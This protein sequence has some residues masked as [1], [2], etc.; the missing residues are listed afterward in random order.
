MLH[1]NIFV[2]LLLSLILLCS[3]AVFPGVKTAAAQE[4]TALTETGLEGQLT[5]EALQALNDDQAEV[6]THNDRVTLVSGTCS[7]E[8]VKSPEDAE[9]VVDSMIGLLGGDAKTHFEPW[10]TFTDGEGNR[11]YVFQQMYANTTVLGGAVKVITDPEGNMIGLSS[12][13]ETELPEAEESEGITAEEAEQIV[14]QYAVEN[15]QPELTLLPDTTAKMILPITIHIDVEEE[16]TEG[17]RFVWVVYTDNPSIRLN[18]AADLPY[19]AHYVT[20]D[21]EYLYSLATIRPGDAAGEAGFDAAYVFEFMEPV[22]YTGYVDLSDGSE[23]ELT[24]T[25]MRDKRTGMYYLGNIERKIVVGDCFEF[26]FN[27]GRVVLASSPDNLE[28]DQVGLLSLYN[29]CKAYDYYKEIGWIGGDG[30]GTPILILNDMCDEHR[31]RIDNAAFIGNYLGWSLFGASMAN[32]LSQ[33]LDVIAHEFTH[34]VTDTVMTY[35]SYMNDYGAINEAISDI[36]GQICDM[37]YGNEA[38][39]DWVI[40]DKSITPVRSMSDPNLFGQPEFSWDLYYFPA[41]NTPT[42]VNDAG[43]VHFNSSLLNN[44]AYRLIADGGMSLE[45]ARAFWFAVDCAMVPGTDYAQLRELMPFVLKILG[46]EKYQT[47]LEQAMDAVR[48]GDHSIPG[49]FDDDRALVTLTLP[50]NENFTDDNWSM[51]IVSVDVNGLILKGTRLISQLISGDYSTFPQEVQDLFKEKDEEPVREE[52]EEEMPGFWEAVLAASLEAIT[53]MMTEETDPEAEA[54]KALAQ[55]QEDERIDEEINILTAWL[56]DEFKDVFYYGV[57]SAGQDGTTI[58]MVARPGRTIPVLMHM[59]LTGISE[60]PDQV[61]FAMY[62]TGKWYA[63]DIP[64]LSSD[65][66]EE[67]IQVEDKEPDEKEADAEM[68]AYVQDIL[69]NVIANLGEIKSLDDVLD[70]FTY[71]IVGGE[72]NEISSNGLET[73]VLP[74]PSEKSEDTTE[75]ELPEPGRKSRPKL[76]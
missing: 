76:D 58:R 46:M 28:W 70:L 24:V 59:S 27:G 12:S 29:Y 4:K 65:P 33:A 6:F 75:M 74:E 64:S 20:M 14:L 2:S 25:V 35:N 23:M 67:N 40:G 68:P 30:Q 22:D 43:G 48:L 57:G 44:V 37:M 18:A 66:D 41:V 61:V 47:T 38:D 54:E 11:Y 16:D 55:A 73:V 21:G 15:N 39:T 56:K 7:E 17:A 9:K 3:A 62:I 5:L 72:V 52:P 60:E 69:A 42:A 19:L 45:E 13:I 36:Q 26:L 53:E 34:C 31:N 10:R 49:F 51:Q 32:D 1:K 71:T 63:L 50:D 8:P